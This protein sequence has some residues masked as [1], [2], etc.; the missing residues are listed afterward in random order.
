MDQLHGIDFK[1]GCFVG[2]EVVQRMERRSTARTRVVPVT[3]DGA[4]PST[5]AEVMAAEKSVGTMGS[6]ADGRGLALLR[7]DRADDA[8]AAGHPLKAGDVTL[9]LV[10][11]DWMQ[12]PFPGESKP[13]GKTA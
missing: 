4:A 13:Q 7:L 6:T 2:Q 12:F 11:P 8:L 5:G 9:H 3:F 10:K 1:K